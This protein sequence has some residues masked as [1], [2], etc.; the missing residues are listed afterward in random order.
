MSFNNIAL[1]AGSSLISKW[2][3]NESGRERGLVETVIRGAI[4]SSGVT[5]FVADTYGN[6]AEAVVSRQ[7]KVHQSLKKDGIKVRLAKNPDQN[8]EEIKEEANLEALWIL[9]ED[10]D[11]TKYTILKQRI[12][13][14]YHTK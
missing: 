3:E 14:K 12:K 7:V 2:A 5:G 8:P 13:D 11:G 9:D 6:Y 10:M 4:S 1:G